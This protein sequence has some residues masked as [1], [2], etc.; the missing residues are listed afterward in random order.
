VV[1][2]RKIRAK[3]EEEIGAKRVK[4]EKAKREKNHENI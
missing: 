3:R 1:K 4:G 2:K